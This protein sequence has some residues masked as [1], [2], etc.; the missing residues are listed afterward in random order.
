M[1]LWKGRKLHTQG[2]QCKADSDEDFVEV[3]IDIP[4]FRF[5]ILNILIVRTAED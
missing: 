1:F 5:K 2:T 3:H 4:V